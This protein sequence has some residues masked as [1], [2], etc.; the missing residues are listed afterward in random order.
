M[1]WRDIPSLAALKGFEAAARAG[2]F[3]AAARELNVTHAAIA[4]H[5]RSV[6]AHLGLSLL[7]REGRKMVLTDAGAQLAG[8]LSNGFGTIIDG[9]TRIVE[10]A[11][12]RPLTVSVTPNFAEYW[13]M[14]RLCGF[15]TK[16]PDV[17]VTVHASNDL[18]DLR[19]DGYDM[20]IRYGDGQ[21][22]GLQSQF[23]VAGDYVV[24]A[25]P[26]L[27]G[28]RKACTIADLQDLTWLFSPTLPVYK[29]WASENG[30]DVDTCTI[31]EVSSMSMITSAVR[32]GGGVSVVIRAMVEDDIA[33][34]RLIAVQ[35]GEA[36]ADLGYYVVSQT[37]AEPEKI[38]TFRKWLQSQV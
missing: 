30:L 27:L 15:W 29:R 10:D 35:E 24:V 22:A 2:S 4:Q 12:T 11:S 6:E 31:R 34:G 13:L 21:Y 9:V 25:T 1:N 8:D 36:P 19:R 28:D 32:A 3:S 33:S 23:L 26:D 37:G 7:N 17:T 18:I 38:K 14:P 16:H 20:A 5:V